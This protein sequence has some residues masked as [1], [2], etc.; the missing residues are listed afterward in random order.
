MLEEFGRDIGNGL[1]TV[2]EVDLKA[3]SSD[4]SHFLRVRV[5]LPLEKPLR[6]G[7][8]VASPKGDKVC[9]GF[10]YERLVGVCFKC[11]RIGHEARG[12]SFHV[13]HQQGL[14]YGEWLK[15]GFHKRYAFANTGGSLGSREVD[16]QEGPSCGVSSKQ[17][18]RDNVNPVLGNVVVG[19]KQDRSQVGGGC[20]DVVP[21]KGGAEIGLASKVG[22]SAKTARKH[23]PDFEELSLSLIKLSSQSLL[24]RIQT[25]SRWSSW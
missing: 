24:F 6:Q 9:I 15:A 25:L 13:D 20:S 23:V 2:V 8:V 14:P 18:D 17:F 3:F 12:C 16:V 11:G 10:K 4:Q 1:G 21:L 7:G 19:S 5:E 22:P